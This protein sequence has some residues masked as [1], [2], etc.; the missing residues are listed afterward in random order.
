MSLRR[1][2]LER[3]IKDRVTGSY[4]AANGVWTPEA[5]DAKVFEDLSIAF[6]T[7]RNE[8][9]KNCCVVVFWSV[10]REVDAQFQIC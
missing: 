4:Y 10:S 9:L 6:Q 7:A 2:E 1:G 8:G 3:V 5:V